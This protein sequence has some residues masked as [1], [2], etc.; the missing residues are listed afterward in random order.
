MNDS[1]S[2][3]ARRTHTISTQALLITMGVVAI[4]AAGLYFVGLTQ[5]RKE[6]SVQ[7]TQYEQQVEEGQQKLNT[8]NAKLVEASNQNHLMKARVALYRTA[9]DLDQRNFGMASGRLQE[10]A[11]ALG[12]IVKSDDS[13]IDVAKVTALKE[14]IETSDFTVAA[15]LESQR[16]LVLDFATTLDGIAADAN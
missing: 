11:D 10:A 8:S 3:A 9:V 1:D 6:L 14:S 5:G 2:A 16:V 13:R 7:K 4:I 12:L 15:D